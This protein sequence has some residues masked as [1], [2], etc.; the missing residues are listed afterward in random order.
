MKLTI[1]ALIALSLA[2]LAGP[3]VF[4]QTDTSSPTSISPEVSTSTPCI[5]SPPAF[6]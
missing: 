1:K 6:F 3:G 4:G 2:V 5:V